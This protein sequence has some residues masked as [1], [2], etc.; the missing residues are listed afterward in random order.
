MRWLVLVAALLTA[1]VFADDWTTEQKVVEGVFLTAIVADFSQTLTI[2][3]ADDEV[4]P[5]LGLS[6]SSGEV[7]QYFA[8]ATVAHWVISALLPSEWRTKFLYTTTGFQAA[9]VLRN[10]R[11]G[12][13]V[14]F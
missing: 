5:V 14:R 9:G 13:R 12:Y 4:N 2:A 1:P 3:K 8:R 11:L 10:Y 7:R 6:P